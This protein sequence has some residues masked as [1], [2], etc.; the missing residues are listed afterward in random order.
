MGSRWVWV[1]MVGLCALTSGC[2]ERGEG[3]TSSAAPRVEAATPDTAE[4][5]ALGVRAPVTNAVAQGPVAQPGTAE[6]RAPPTGTQVR[7]PT[8]AGSTASAPAGANAATPGSQPAASGTANTAPRTTTPGT[9]NAS[10]GTAGTPAT[11]TAAAGAGTATPG[12][13]GTAQAPARGG[14]VMIGSEAVQAS[15]DEAWHLGAAR[16]AKDA[17]TGGSGNAGASLEDVVIA[18]SSVSGRVTRVGNDVITVRDQEG[19]VYELQL[20]RRSRG[21]RQGRK[22]S[23]RGLEEGTPVRAQFVLMGGRTVARDVQ[24]RR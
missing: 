20:D 5:G 11:G 6:R 7:E 13:T 17:A 8:G 2:H 12:A 15:D 22:V 3:N 24:I 14:R 4:A 16:A 9:A 18:S 10:T 1:G 23:L 21:L 19:G